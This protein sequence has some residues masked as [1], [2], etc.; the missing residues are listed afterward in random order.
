MKGLHSLLLLPLLVS[1]NLYAAGPELSLVTTFSSLFL[2]LGLIVLLAWLTKKLRLSQLGGAGS[3]M[4]VV[5][6]LPLGAKER[7]VVVEVGNEQ[8]LIGVTAQQVNLIKTLAEPLPEEA[9]P[10]FAEQLSKLMK[11]DGMD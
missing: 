11:K 4:R 8:L 6:Q 9:S 3:Q 10:Q 1:G 2:V 5:K 7:L